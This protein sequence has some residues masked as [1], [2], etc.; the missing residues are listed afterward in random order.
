M[1]RHALKACY[2]GHAAR[3]LKSASPCARSGVQRDLASM[4]GVTAAALRA[5]G[6]AD[7]T[8]RAMLKKCAGACDGGVQV[9]KV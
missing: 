2:G 3:L 6:S 8:R 7:E 5:R 4:D 1:A 9:L